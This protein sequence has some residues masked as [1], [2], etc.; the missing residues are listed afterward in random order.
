MKQQILNFVR[1]RNGKSSHIFLETT[2]GVHSPVMSGT[3]QVDFYRPLR[4]PTLLVGDCHLGGIT[5]TLTSYES[6]YIRGYDI[7]FIFFFDHPTHKN[8]KFVGERVKQFGTD[9]VAIPM[10]PELLQDPL[11]NRESMFEY[12]RNLDV[13][14]VPVMKWLTSKHENRFDK[15]ESMAEISREIFWWPFTQHATVKVKWCRRKCSTASQVGGRK[16]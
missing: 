12:Y 15:L 7:P 10:P 16:D 1:Q 3:S 6:L 5:T 11:R 14:L 8:H 4:L 9:V 13:F 2:G